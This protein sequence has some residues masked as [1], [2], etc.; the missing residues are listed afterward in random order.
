MKTNNDILTPKPLT[1]DDII[2]AARN[3]RDEQN[4]AL[5]TPPEFRTAKVEPLR[6]MAW[7]RWAAAA[8]LTGFLAGFGVSEGVTRL[9]GAAETTAPPVVQNIV[10]LD[11]VFMHETIR[12]T[13]YQTRVVVREIPS[14]AMVAQASPTSSAA[15]E[16]LPDKPEGVGCSMLCDDIAYELLAG[17]SY[18]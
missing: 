17:N 18:R 5:A 4:E 2:A 15:T 3:L 11:T 14:K 6:P 8:C 13:V 9:S 16:E 10:Q 12:D 1:D 7:K